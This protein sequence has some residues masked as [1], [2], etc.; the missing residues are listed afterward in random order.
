MKVLVVD[1]QRINRVLPMTILG[2]LGLAV[3]EAASGEVAV[4]SVT[5]DPAIS[6]VLL[7][8]SMPGMSGIEVCQHLRNMPRETPIYIVAYTAHAFPGEQTQ[9]MQSGFDDL[10]IKPINRDSL[11]KA[12]GLSPNAV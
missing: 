10:L 8:I 6:H 5:Q 7:D 2:K 12:L 11:L 1:D 9:I 3:T 4:H